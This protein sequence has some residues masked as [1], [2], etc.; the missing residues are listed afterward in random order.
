MSE[1]GGVAL[2]VASNTGNAF[3]F[4]KDIL[5]SL[6]GY[7][8]SEDKGGYLR[9]WI[10]GE[11]IHAHNIILERPKNSVA[12]HINRNIRDNRR[13]NLR[14]VTRQHNKANSGVPKNNKSGFKG[15][16]FYSKYQKYRA[17]IKVDYK[18]IFLGYFETPGEAANAYDVAAIKY[19]GNY[20]LTNKIIRGTI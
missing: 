13:C 7:T 18:H 4:D 2:I 20:A 14:T 5:P 6:Q 15:V 17:Y 9:A 12:D 16:S 11:S 10:K 19:F 1:E 3:I 8:W